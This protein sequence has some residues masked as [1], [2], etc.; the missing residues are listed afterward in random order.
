MRGRKPQSSNVYEPRS[1]SYYPET[2][3]RIWGQRVHLYHDPGKPSCGSRR[4]EIGEG[5]MPIW[6][7]LNMLSLWATGA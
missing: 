4:T 7:T 5:R 3:S 2:P 6:C 1:E